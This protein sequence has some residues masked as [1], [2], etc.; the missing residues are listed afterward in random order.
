MIVLGHD[1]TNSLSDEDLENNYSDY[2]VDVRCSVC[3]LLGWMYFSSREIIYESDQWSDKYY[4]SI[5][6][7]KVLDI[8]CNEVLIKKLLE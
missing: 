7:T 4:S 1:F 8:T 6:D 3:G 5:E 2:A